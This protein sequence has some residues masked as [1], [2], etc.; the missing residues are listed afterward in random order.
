[1]IFCF[2]FYYLIKHGV[3]DTVISSM[4]CPHTLHSNDV[5]NIVALSLFSFFAKYSI[6][7]NDK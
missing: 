4:C 1:M 5:V 2:N 6:Q 3:A 7:F